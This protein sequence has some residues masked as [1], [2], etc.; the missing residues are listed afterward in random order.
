MDSSIIIGLSLISILYYLGNIVISPMM[1]LGIMTEQDNIEIEKLR[2]KYYVTIRLFQKH[3]GHRGFTMFGKIYININM[4]NKKVSWSADKNSGLKWTFFHEYWHYKNWHFLKSILMRV[5]QSCVPLLLFI[6]SHIIV[7]GIY[8][9]VSIM[10]MYVS[11]YF[12][13]EAD[14]YANKMT[15][16]EQCRR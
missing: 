6:F 9:L 2:R 7:I 3:T 12:E 8:V 5:V 13:S 10:I 11:Q 16:Y 15:G 14:E 1:K 4:K